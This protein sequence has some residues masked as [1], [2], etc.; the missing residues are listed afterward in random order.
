MISFDKNRWYRVKPYLK[1]YGLIAGIMVFFIYSNALFLEFA[2]IA[3]K[4][5]FFWLSDRIY[6]TYGF[7]IGV[8]AM[9]I[10]ISSPILLGVLLLVWAGRSK[11]KRVAVT[12][13]YFMQ[14]Y[15][16]LVF[17]PKDCKGIGVLLLYCGLWLLVG[18]IMLVVWIRWKCEQKA[19][20]KNEDEKKS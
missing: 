13:Y 4:W 9:T 1:Q 2:G 8:L 14:F 5:P 17:N 19:E 20:E 10:G 3:A 11:M 7:G 18:I 12:I 16:F 15:I 6:H